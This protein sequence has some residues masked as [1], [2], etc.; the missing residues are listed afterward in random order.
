MGARKKMAARAAAWA[1]NVALC[2]I[3][4]TDAVLSLGLSR[5]WQYLFNFFYLFVAMPAL[6]YVSIHDK[7]AVL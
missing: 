7:D 4:I 2:G 3:V 1:L 6:L 5:G